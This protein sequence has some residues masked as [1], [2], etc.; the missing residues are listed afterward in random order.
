MKK[1]RETLIV[2]AICT[3]IFLIVP[4]IRVEIL[5]WQH[6]SEFATL[7]RLTNMIDGIDYFKVMDYSDTSARVYYVGNNRVTGSLL[8]FIRKDGQW[9]LERWD[10]VWSR[11]GSADDF[12][13]PYYR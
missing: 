9:V 4:Y 13:W 3:L 11:T 12:I 6:G 8:R 10:T 5:T 1:F 7:Y 2:I